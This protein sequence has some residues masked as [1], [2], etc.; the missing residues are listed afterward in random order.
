MSFDARAVAMP[1]TPPTPAGGLR[2]PL[3]DGGTGSE[4]DFTRLGSRVRGAFVLVETVE[5]TDVQGLF[6]EYADAR[7]IDDLARQGGARGVVVMASR[8]G[9][10]LYRHFPSAGFDNTLTQVILEREAAERALRLLR[11]GRELTLD[12]DVDAE[13]GGPY[14]SHNVIGE[15]EGEERPDEIVLIAAHL[16]SWDLGTGGLDNG[17]NVVMLIDGRTTIYIAR[18]PSA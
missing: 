11:A 1:F 18:V 14:A 7:A 15:I 4:A 2:A 17:C 10:V 6:R 8:P 3:L 12:V 9:A 16:D 13:T 5:L